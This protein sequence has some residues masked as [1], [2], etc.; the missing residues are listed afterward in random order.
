MND[1]KL[2]QRLI[3]DALIDPDGQLDWKGRPKRLWNAINGWTFVGVAT[4]E[5]ELAYNCYPE[6]PATDL[7]EE[8]ARRAERSIDD[9][10]RK[11]TR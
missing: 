9:L 6:T 4:G 11:E 1:V 8:L 3:E 5:T 2:R 7:L 10:L